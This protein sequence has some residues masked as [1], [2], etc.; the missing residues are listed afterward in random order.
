MIPVPLSLVPALQARLVGGRVFESRSSYF[1]ASEIGLCLRATIGGKLEPQP[2]DALSMGRM[3]AGRALENEI[4]QIIRAMLPGQVRET[5]RAQQELHHP[6]LP[7]RAHPDGRITGDSGDALLEVKTASA[8][9]FKRYVEHGLPEHYVDQVQAQMGLAGIHK[10]I[11]VLAS[12]ENLAQVQ[13]FEVSFEPGRFA[14]LEERAAT[15]ALHLAQGTLPEG[16][17]ERGFCVTCPMA[18]SCGAM[19]ERRSA[20][21]RGEIPALLKLQLE[22]QAEELSE[23]ESSLEPLLTRASELREQIRQSL[24][25][26]GAKRIHL[27]SAT[28]QLVSNSRTSFDSKAL[29]RESPEIYNRFLKTTTFTNLRVSWKRGEP[30]CLPTAS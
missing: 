29:L 18:S 30:S 10:A 21:Q 19:Q 2:L 8:A 13:V 12:R 22:A 4:V 1:G 3:L 7:F 26:S 11:V 16:E 23:L 25:L 6:E 27:D 28:V 9:T 5:G 14:L 17:P 24:D 20:G 15:G